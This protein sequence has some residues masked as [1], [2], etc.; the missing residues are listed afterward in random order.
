M[1]RSHYRHNV[2]ATVVFY[3]SYPTSDLVETEYPKVSKQRNWVRID[4]EARFKD[5]SDFKKE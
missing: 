4:N 1:K 5:L 2:H 3:S